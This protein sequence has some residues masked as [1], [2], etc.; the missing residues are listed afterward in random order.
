MITVSAQLV[1]S[2]ETTTASNS[3]RG[4]G[5]SFHSPCYLGSELWLQVTEKDAKLFQLRP[6]WFLLLTS[7]PTGNLF[8]FFLNRR[9]TF[10]S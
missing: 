9:I 1:G 2:V 8:F 5:P 3:S 6:G 7:A 4:S 10:I